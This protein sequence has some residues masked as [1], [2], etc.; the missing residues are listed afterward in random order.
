MLLG[1][2]NLVLWNDDPEEENTWEYA[3]AVLYFCKIISIFNYDYPKKA[4]ATYLPIALI[5][6]IT[7]PT[8][9]LKSGVEASTKQKYSWHFIA[10][11]FSKGTKK[12]WTF[13]FYLVFGL[14]S[15]AS[16][17]IFQSYAHSL[18][19]QSFPL[20]LL[21]SRFFFLDISQK[22]FSINNQIFWFF[23]TSFLEGLEVFYQWIHRFFSTISYQSFGVFFN[24]NHIYLHAHWSLRP[25]R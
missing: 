22:V 15:I 1:L 8:I 18:I 7:K 24:Y 2:Y 17:K 6:P 4:I 3:L 13:G 19:F 12:S 9:K 23:S 21:N 14:F 20:I 11:G 25:R 16:K 10:N 5:S